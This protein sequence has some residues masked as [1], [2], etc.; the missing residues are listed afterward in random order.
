MLAKYKQLLKPYFMKAASITAKP[1][2]VKTVFNTISYK[3]QTYRIFLAE[4]FQS[5][6]NY[7]I[8]KKIQYH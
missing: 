4:G 6:L 1:I 5:L 2:Y 7:A 3:S 8:M